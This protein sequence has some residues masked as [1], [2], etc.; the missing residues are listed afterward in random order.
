[1]LWGIKHILQEVI[2]F[3]VKNQYDDIIF[4]RL[5]ALDASW[6]CKTIACVLDLRGEVCSWHSQWSQVDISLRTF[7]APATN[8]FDQKLHS[9][10]EL[11]HGKGTV[12]NV[13]LRTTHCDTLLLAKY[14]WYTCSKKTIRQHAD[15]RHASLINV[16]CSLTLVVCMH[17]C[18]HT[19]THRH[20]LVHC[21]EWWLT[22]LIM[23]WHFTD[24]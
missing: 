13:D 9:L 10:Y 7:W 20:C 22:R 4:D 6:H 17:N 2:F 1:M 15:R 8:K 19:I 5:H 18:G 24:A 12:L 14:F 23:W 16:C 11:P 3:G 21:S